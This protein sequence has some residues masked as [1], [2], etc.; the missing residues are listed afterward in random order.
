MLIHQPS[1]KKNAVIYRKTAS[2]S[3]RT[4][5]YK[6]SRHSV[7]NTLVK[8]ILIVAISFIAGGVY[9]F[10]FFPSWKISQVNLPE[11]LPTENSEQ[12]K[13]LI[14]N[15]INDYLNTK[16]YFFIPHN[17]Y[18]FFAEAEL[19]DKLKN[20]GLLANW[21]I[22]MD[23]PKTISIEIAKNSTAFIWRSNE[24]NYLIDQNGQLLA[25]FKNSEFFNLGMITVE[26]TTPSTT[27][28]IVEGLPATAGVGKA[29][30]NSVIEPKLAQLILEIDQ[31]YKTD[32]YKDLAKQTV[33]ID[34]PLAGYLKIIL[35]GGAEV[36]INYL[37]NFFNQINK[38]EQAMR[39]GKIDLTKIK[40][41]N[42]RVKDQVILQ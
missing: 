7:I 13:Q 10:F 39:A 34:G 14:N 8:I 9:L 22:K 31:Y 21:L 25:N 16:R 33:K 4:N 3:A 27:Q 32:P 18:F 24:Q 41:I 23:F 37:E 40:I 5:L 35:N 6:P 42:L 12:V 19:L 1:Y 11:T 2:R 30:Q 28:L 36:Q 15:E 26:D 38:L 17:G 20:K 29:G